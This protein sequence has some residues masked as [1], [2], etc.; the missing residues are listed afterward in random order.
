MADGRICFFDSHSNDA[1]T[2]LKMDPHNGKAIL[3]KFATANMFKSYILRRYAHQ[4]RWKDWKDVDVDIDG[5]DFVQDNNGV[6]KKHNNG[7]RKKHVVIYDSRSIDELLIRSRCKLE[8]IPIENPITESS[9]AALTTGLSSPIGT[10]NSRSTEKKSSTLV[11]T[12]DFSLS[13]FYVDG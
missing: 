5:I 8:Y 3:L 4:S 9:S 10:R 2:G 7:V 6:G 1:E 13:F 12:Y 11:S